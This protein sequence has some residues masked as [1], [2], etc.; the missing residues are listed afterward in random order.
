MAARSGTWAV[1]ARVT[2]SRMANAR[3]GAEDKSGTCIGH[4]LPRRLAPPHH[5]I[6]PHEV[7]MQRTLLT[8]VVGVGHFNPMVPLAR[9]FQAA[10]H[11]VAFAT[12]PGLDRKSTRLNSSHLGI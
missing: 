10:G 3:F 9:A 1:T 4:P 12:D 8:C 7:M 2:E 11:D 6:V 5:R